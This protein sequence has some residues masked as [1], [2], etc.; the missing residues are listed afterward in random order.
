MATFDPRN[1]IPLATYRDRTDLFT[2][3]DAA[4]SCLLFLPVGALLAARPLGRDGLAR[5]LRPGVL[6][7]LGIELGQL[8]IADRWPDVTDILIQTA[9]LA[10]GVALIRRAAPG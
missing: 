10:I 1:L 9:G 5:G 2:V 3:A 7:V 4:I 8:F 6:L